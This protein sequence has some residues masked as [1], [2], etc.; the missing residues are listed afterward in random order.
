MLALPFFFAYQLS[1]Y[2]G[3]KDTDGPPRLA[4]HKY[5]I[6]D[7]CTF[8][9]SVKSLTAEVVV[10]EVDRFMTIDDVKSL[11]HIKEGIPNDQQRLIFS[12]KQ[13]EVGRTLQCE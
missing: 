1:D 10:L 3:D 13:L 4:L 12:G 2:L 6:R 5:P 8:K 9:I 11:I 7:P